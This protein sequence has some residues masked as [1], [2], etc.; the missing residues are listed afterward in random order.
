MKRPV[1]M[2]AWIYAPEWLSLSEAAALSGPNPA[3]VESLIYDAGMDARE[4]DG[5]SLISK[6]SLREYLETALEA[7]QG[8][9]G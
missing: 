1:T 7:A 8:L 9:W 3:M 6:E 4:A 5:Q 2:V